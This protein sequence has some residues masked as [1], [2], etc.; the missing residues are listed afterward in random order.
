M[1]RR[2]SSEKWFPGWLGS[3]WREVRPN[4]NPY[5]EL[6]LLFQECGIKPRNIQLKAVAN[7]VFHDLKETFNVLLFVVDVDKKPSIKKVPEGEE[8]VWV[9]E[10]SLLKHD[11]VLEEYR[12]VLPKLQE[13]KIIFYHTEYDFDKMLNL[14][15][16][17]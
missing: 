14:E 6:K 12:K 5:Q 3:L 4:H 2:K 15:F 8:I 17:G 16:Y 10:E 9:S 13:N 11:E 1:V 7:N